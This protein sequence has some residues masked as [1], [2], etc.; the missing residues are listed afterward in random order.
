MIWIL[1]AYLVLG[2]VWVATALVMLVRLRRAALEL[3]DA[4]EDGNWQGLR[5]RIRRLVK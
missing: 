4:M 5:A 2:A 3:A 1:I